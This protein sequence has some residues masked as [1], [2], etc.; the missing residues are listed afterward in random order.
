MNK[1]HEENLSEEGSSYSSE[2]GAQEYML[3][4]RVQIPKAVNVR[5]MKLSKVVGL[6]VFLWSCGGG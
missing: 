4:R 6:D 1:K 2:N 3:Y 5:R